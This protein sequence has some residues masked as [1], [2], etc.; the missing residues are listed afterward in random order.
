MK[1]IRIEG[2]V[3]LDLVKLIATKLFIYANSGFGKSWLLRWFL[4]QTFSQI[5]Q[6]IIDPEGEFST[7]REKF[8]YVLIGK[9][10]DFDIQA[11][12]RSAALLA[13]RLLEEKVSAIID[14]YELEPDQRDAFVANFA[15]ALVNVPK[16]LQHPYLFVVDE[17]QDFAP[18]KG[19]T[20]SAGPL[21]SLAKKGRK[22][23]CCPVFATQRVSDFSKAVIA[24][25]NNKLIGQASLDIDM[26]R[27]AS[28]LGFST[29]DQMMALRDL[30]PGEF[31][32]FG[33]AI[34]KIVQKVK[35][36]AVRTT[37]PDSSKMGS[38][39]GTKVVPASAKVKKALAALADLPQQAAEEAKTIGELRVKVRELERASKMIAVKPVI[40]DPRSIENAVANAIQ[41]RD[42][43]WVKIVQGWQYWGEEIFEFLRRILRDVDD[44]WEKVQR[45]PAV[46][47][48]TI[49]QRGVTPL[50][51]V[52]DARPV[53]AIKRT[54]IA[55]TP[56]TAN[57]PLPRGD[58]D[59][60]KMNKGEVEIL[61]AIA[62]DSEGVTNEHIAVLTG[63]KGTSRYEYIR[64]L[65]ARGFIEARGDV[66]W[67]TEDGLQY[68]GPNFEPLPT[69]RGLLD[70]WLGKLSG[71][72]LKI[73]KL[74]V[75]A[76]DTR[77]GMDKTEISQASGYQA[78]STYEYL[79]KLVA[80]K[81]VLFDNG[82]ACVN[83]KL[84]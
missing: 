25:C 66:F 13:H 63:Y 57:E 8:D 26:K 68:L 32:A 4:E 55:I 42:K 73:F 51:V 17:A 64:K 34:S 10:P 24:A 44:K 18:E 43:E 30:D 74:L 72:E 61:R 78:T 36:G 71:G 19:N 6:I 49:S 60:S 48:P 2:D 84:L 69:G 83:P 65:K 59:T 50:P 7:L 39:I 47:P 46:A 80:R 41:K 52:P 27:C 9:G 76:S 28:E 77:M 20:L 82:V 1:K 40:I 12:P 56:A 58:V 29:K 33:P 23:G 5:Q 11:D 15:R 79:R 70:Y 67:V 45:R 31:Y 21:H 75:E 3:Y 35:I 53:G 38:K 37:H 22:R 81:I 62:G 54:A 14:L 16:N